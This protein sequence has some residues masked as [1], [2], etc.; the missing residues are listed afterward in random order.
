MRIG[1]MCEQPP[2]SE[3]STS[4]RAWAWVPSGA[5]DVAFRSFLLTHCHPSVV[6]AWWKSWV[7]DPQKPSD[8]NM[9]RT[10][11]IHVHHAYCADL[12]SLRKVYGC[13]QRRGTCTN[14]FTKS[15]GKIA[16][17]I[18]QQLEEIHLTF[19]GH[20]MLGEVC[21]GDIGPNIV[22]QAVREPACSSMNLIV[23][24][25]ED[26]RPISGVSLWSPGDGASG[27]WWERRP[28]DHQGRPAW[29]GHRCCPGS[30]WRGGRRGLEDSA[31][32][33]VE[34]A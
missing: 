1:S 11:S 28:N 18:L 2:W 32:P 13:Q 4:G 9:K 30:S 5:G 25:F 23:V 33:R 19:L 8:P 16:R 3:R 24:T 15:S 31:H 10:W 22:S 21:P 27:E 29:V 17:Y 6:M 26:P 7:P 20:G 14:V 34:T 12:P